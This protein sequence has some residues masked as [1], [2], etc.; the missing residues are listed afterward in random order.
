MTV[1]KHEAAVQTLVGGNAHEKISAV[2]FIK[3]SIIG[4]RSNKQL[5]LT[6]GIL[7]QYD[8]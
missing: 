7:R 1:Q 4:N 3:N 8:N 2:R 5:Y 6:L